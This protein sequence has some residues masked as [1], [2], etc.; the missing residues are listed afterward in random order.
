MHGDLAAVCGNDHRAVG[1][2]VF[3]KR[4]RQQEGRRAMFRIEAGQ[5]DAPVVFRAADDRG[6]AGRQLVTQGIEGEGQAVVGRAVCDR[7]EQ[8]LE[9]LG[10]FG[11]LHPPSKISVRRGSYTPAHR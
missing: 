5:G 4:Q 8:F 11:G 2:A 9:Q 1:G 7:R 6:E 10:L 3:V